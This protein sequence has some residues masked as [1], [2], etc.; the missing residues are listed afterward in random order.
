MLPGYRQ[1]PDY[2]TAVQ[3]K[4]YNQRSNAITNTVLYS[5]H[6]DIHSAVHTQQV[7]INYVKF[8]AKVLIVFQIHFFVTRTTLHLTHIV[9]L[10]VCKN[11]IAHCTIFNIHFGIK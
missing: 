11:H 5:S 2:E 7:S 9:S 3:Q 8:N 1:A 4:Y 10:P 6:P